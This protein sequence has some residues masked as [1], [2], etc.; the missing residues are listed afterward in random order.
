M[1]GLSE[2]TVV[3]ENED[4]DWQR[5]VSIRSDFKLGSFLL[6]GVEIETA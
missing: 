2:V 3:S 5:D 4:P 6:R 1:R